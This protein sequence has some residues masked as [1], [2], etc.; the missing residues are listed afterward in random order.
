M[1]RLSSYSSVA[2]L[3]ERLTV[4]QDVAGSSPAR[5]ATCSHL[6]KGIGNRPLKPVIRVRFPVGSSMTLWTNW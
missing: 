2:Q 3:E 4:N 5:G 6:L 1:E